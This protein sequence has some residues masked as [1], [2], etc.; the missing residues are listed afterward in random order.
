MNYAQQNRYQNDQEDYG[1]SQLLL[2]EESE[3]EAVMA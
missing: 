2:T 3:E 1:R